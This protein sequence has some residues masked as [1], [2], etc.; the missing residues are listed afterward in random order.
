MPGFVSSFLFFR[1]G[2]I[3]HLSCC[4]KIFQ[5]TDTILFDWWGTEVTISF[6]LVTDQVSTERKALHCRSLAQGYLAVDESSMAFFHYSMIRIFCRSRSDKKWQCQGLVP[7]LPQNS[8]KQSR[9]SLTLRYKFGNPRKGIAYLLLEKEDKQSQ[10][11][12]P[13][14]Q[15]MQ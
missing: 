15:R 14:H 3:L 1:L 10:R 2:C 13:W 11:C 9:I 8:E 7:F 4:E 12:V 6:K 5:V